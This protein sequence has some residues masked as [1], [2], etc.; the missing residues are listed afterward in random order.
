MR[1]TIAVILLLAGCSS[2]PEQVPVSPAD[3][4]NPRIEISLKF[5]DLPKDSQ[6]RQIRGKSFRFG[7]F[8]RIT[9]NT[10]DFP[11]C[12]LHEYLECL[13]GL[14]HGDEPNDD[15]CENPKGKENN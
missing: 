11:G 4:N 9:L 14:F 6:G 2:I 8:C 1:P 7:N 10:G 5:E 12:L 15:Y 13:L 3:I